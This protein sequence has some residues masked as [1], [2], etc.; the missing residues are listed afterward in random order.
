MSREARATINQAG[1]SAMLVKTPSGVLRRSPLMDANRDGA[2]DMKDYEAE[3]DITL[4]GST[5]SSF[6]CPER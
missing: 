1:V 4:A 5:G 2:Q 6:R 3:K